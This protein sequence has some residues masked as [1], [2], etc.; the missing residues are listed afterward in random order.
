MDKP[1]GETKQYPLANYIFTDLDDPD[2]SPVAIL[3]PRRIHVCTETYPFKR[4]G[5]CIRRH[6]SKCSTILGIFTVMPK[7]HLVSKIQEENCCIRLK[8]RPDVQTELSNESTVRVKDIS[9]I[10]AECRIRKSFPIPIPI[11]ILPVYI[12]L[13][14]C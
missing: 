4:P 9:F 11:I 10:F 6:K 14:L 8:D 1:P 2:L 7:R 13:F 5:F 3:P 12:F